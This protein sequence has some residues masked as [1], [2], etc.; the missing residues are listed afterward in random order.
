VGVVGCSNLSHFKP[1]VLKAAIALL[2]LLFGFVDGARLSFQTVQHFDLAFLTHKEVWELNGRRIVCR[3]DLDSRPDERYG[4][5]AYDCAS[6]D[7]ICRTFWLLRGQQIE[8]TMTVEATLRLRY[9]Q[10]D[11]TQGE[12]RPEKVQDLPLGVW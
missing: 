10:D 6:P 2:L 5:I 12:R 11:S 8:D 1:M 7:D 9:V 3:V 4:Y